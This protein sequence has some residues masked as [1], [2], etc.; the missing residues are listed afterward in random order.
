MSNKQQ[1]IL[2]LRAIEKKNRGFFEVN[3]LDIVN[4][5]VI[6]DDGRYVSVHILSTVNLPFEIVYDIE[7]MFW[8]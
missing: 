1:C 7:S 8:Q 4:C 6:I 5:V 2:Y 3:N